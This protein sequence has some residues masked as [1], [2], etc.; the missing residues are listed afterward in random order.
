RRSRDGEGAR[1]SVPRRAPVEPVFGAHQVARQG[2]VESVI[3]RRRPLHQGSE[4]TSM[5]FRTLTFL[6]SSVTWIVALGGCGS[7]SDVTLGGTDD[8]GTNGDGGTIDS[9]P[10][11]ATFPRLYLASRGHGLSIWNNV[12]RVAA[13]RSPDAAIDVP[14]S[15]AAQ[16]AIRGDRLFVT[17]NIPNG[18][19]SDPVRIFD[20]ASTLSSGASPSDTLPPSTFPSSLGAELVQVD[21]LGELW[22]NQQSGPWLV[23]D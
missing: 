10:P 6:C 4:A 20:G 9:G 2:R 17:A 11:P 23:G 14:P 19:T 16:L 18:L 3:D 22:T 21:A 8:T 12:D 5:S 13:D 1:E 7:A 15:G